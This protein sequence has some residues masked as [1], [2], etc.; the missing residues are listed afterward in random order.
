MWFLQV[1]K[2]LSEGELLYVEVFFGSGP[3]A[4]YLTAL[5]VKIFGCHIFLIKSL[6][7][8]IYALHGSI[9]LKIF[10]LFS[11]K[12]ENYWSLI[13]LLL[14]FPDPY[15]S[16]GGSLYS[17]LAS[18][19]L[20]SAFYA[21]QK[22]K[23]FLAAVMAIACLFTKQN[24][25]ALA[26]VAVLLATPSNQK[27]KL[28][29][30][31]ILSSIAGLSLFLPQLTSGNGKAVFDFMFANKIAY[32]QNAPL[33]YLENAFK[34]FDLTGYQTISGIRIAARYL[35]YFLPALCLLLPLKKN[36]LTPTLFISA[37]LAATFPRCDIYHLMIAAPGL[38]FGVSLFFE[39]IHNKNF[40]R[41]FCRLVF[42][43]FFATLVT[44]ELFWSVNRMSDQHLTKST[45]P[46][47]SG[48][49]VN[50][51][52]EKKAQITAQKLT[53]SDKLYI[54]S[55][56]AAL[57]YL[58]SNQPNLTP[59]DYPLLTTFRKNDQKKII[60][61]IETGIIKN[62]CYS[63]YSDQKLAAQEIE[64][65]MEKKTFKIGETP[66]CQIKRKT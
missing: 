30:Y 57:L 1:V 45:L 27:F 7:A 31:M 54:Q 39:L 42:M 14:I 56:M 16:A 20:W 21:L 51:D 36:L 17:P 19:L 4:P 18:L 38:C 65:F 28:V 48:A 13:G 12:R 50:Q 59:Y 66:L 6:G 46:Y 22:E 61:M 52:F 62:I 5:G 41:L 2:R 43:I 64:D 53:N 23:F 47:L 35:I 26:I 32:L 34:L 58:I 25:G 63:K 9:L 33:S 44:I 3:L 10:L 40:L 60:Q 15:L 11:P 37:D 55:D 24:T 49:I 8:A 29:K